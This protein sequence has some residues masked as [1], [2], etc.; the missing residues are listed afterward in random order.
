MTCPTCSDRRGDPG[1]CDVNHCPERP[2]VRIPVRGS[3]PS[4]QRSPLL[5]EVNLTW[6]LCRPHS[7]RPDDLVETL[8]GLI[9]TRRKT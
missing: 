6:K 7:D 9:D 8:H 2:V 1:L 3:K 5:K 4:A